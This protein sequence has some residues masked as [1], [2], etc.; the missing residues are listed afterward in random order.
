MANKTIKH[1]VTVR[2][3]E[4]K[5]AGYIHDIFDVNFLSERVLLTKNNVLKTLENQTNKNFEIIFLVNDK[6]LSEEKYGFIFTELNT[7]ITLPIKFMNSGQL[8]Q[9]VK[10]TYSDYDFVIQSRIDYDD[11]VYKD[12][13][14]DTQSKIEECEN[15]LSY[16]YSQ[17]YV[18]FN[19]EL[20]VFPLSRYFE[21]G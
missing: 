12:A 20:Y 9:L 18:Y 7:E 21:S 15:I 8:R 11:F 5:V 1:F 2:F 19:G 14:A 3:F 13:V 6:Y 16:G 17:G 10:E 4:K